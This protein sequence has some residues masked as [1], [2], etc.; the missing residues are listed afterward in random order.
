MLTRFTNKVTKLSMESIHFTI[1]LPKAGRANGSAPQEAE[2]GSN[3]H[4]SAGQTEPAFS[5]SP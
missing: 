2:A 5:T 1:D 3:G 4:L